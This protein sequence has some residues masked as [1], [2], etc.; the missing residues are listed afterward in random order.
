[1]IIEG[2]F[3]CARVFAESLDESTE[4][5]VRTLCD[6]EYLAKSQIR[7]MPDVHAGVGCT[8]GTTMTLHGRVAPSMVGVDIGC[9]MTTVRLAR[10][11]ANLDRLDA[12]IRGS[13]PVGREIRKKPHA[14]MESLDLPSLRCFAHINASRARC[15]VGTLGGGNHFIELERGEDEALYLVIHS[16][17]RHLGV[18]V[19]EYYQKE[20]YRHLDADTKKALPKTL[21]YVEGELFDDYLHDMALVQRFAALNRRAMVQDILDGLN[22]D[23]DDRFETIHNYIDLDAMILRKGAV[24]A[25]AGERLLIP[26]NMRDGSLLCEGL[27]N[28]EWNQSAPHGAGRLMSRK[29]AQNRV[30]L[31]AFKDSMKG[32]FT[33]CVGKDT[34]DES[35]MAYKPMEDIL[36]FIQPTA[37]V[38]QRLLP[39]YNFK[40]GE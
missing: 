30:T 39:I 10:R 11:K 7:I 19:S 16:G 28:A 32:I 27:G 26:I 1:M 20:G 34:L 15:S 24:S 31:K 8:I 33:T 22:W 21:A 40:A 6:L 35:P 13:I 25:K 9:G 29:E 36:R 14:L 4:E 17:S 2:K 3:N 37:R 23:E 12:L 18:E 38:S 5:Q